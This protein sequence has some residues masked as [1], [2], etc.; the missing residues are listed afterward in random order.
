MFSLHANPGRLPRKTPDMKRIERLQVATNAVRILVPKIREQ[1][2]YHP[3]T[4]LEPSRWV[5]ESLGYR[6][7]LVEN[8]LLSPV[9]PSLSSLL[10][11]WPRAGGKQFSASWYADRP[12]VPPRVICFHQGAW[13]DV[14]SLCARSVEGD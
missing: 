8:I 13:M 6:L 11:I 7:S 1:G 2:T 5:W 14:F 3:A 12:W 4:A 10:D 9:E